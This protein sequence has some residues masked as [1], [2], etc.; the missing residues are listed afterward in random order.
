MLPI[1]KTYKTSGHSIGMSQEQRIRRW[2][3]VLLLAAVSAAGKLLQLR[4][5]SAACMHPSKTGVDC[6]QIDCQV[7]PRLRTAPWPTLRNG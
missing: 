3:S 5:A 6:D 2:A 4:L 1:P 7:W